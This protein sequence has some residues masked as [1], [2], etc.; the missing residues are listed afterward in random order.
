MCERKEPGMQDPLLGSVHG[1]PVAEW[2]SRGVKSSWMPSPMVPLISGELRSPQ[3][4]RSPLTE[5]EI[6]PLSSNHCTKSWTLAH[7]FFS[8]DGQ[9][10]LFSSFSRTH[11]LD[12]KY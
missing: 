4:P 10:A 9:L 2:D 3:V 7:L 5:E 1:F 6:S 12:L 8:Q 11:T